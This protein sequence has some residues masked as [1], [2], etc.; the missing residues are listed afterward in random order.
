MLRANQAALQVLMGGQWQ[1]VFCHNRGLLVT[2]K[3]RRKALPGYDLKCF[4]SKFGNDVFRAEKH[5]RDISDE[6]PDFPQ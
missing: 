6:I 4:R 3:D 1:F 5:G 2:T